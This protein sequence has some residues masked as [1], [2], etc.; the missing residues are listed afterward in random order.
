M[1]E[2][3]EKSVD[4]GYE[5]QSEVLYHMDEAIRNF[6]NGNVSQPVDLSDFDSVCGAEVTAAEDV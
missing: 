3:T 6:K 5:I 4:T 1:I 2:K